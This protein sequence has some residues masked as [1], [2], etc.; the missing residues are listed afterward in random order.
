M[1][2][3]DG[4]HALFSHSMG[5]VASS[6]CTVPLSDSAGMGNSVAREDVRSSSQVALSG[7]DLFRGR[8]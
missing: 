7:Y 5:L 3:P 1:C 4:G 6:E 8:A 2:V